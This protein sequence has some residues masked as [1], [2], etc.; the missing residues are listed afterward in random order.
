[1]NSAYYYRGLLWKELRY[2]ARLFGLAF[3]LISWQN[4]FFPVIRG[5]LREGVTFAEWYT[6]LLYMMNPHAFSSSFM[7]QIGIIIS[8]AMGVLILNH[9]RSGSL[10]YLLS[11]PVHRKEIIVSK[12]ISGSLALA[13]IMFINAL[14]VVL[15]LAAGPV[16]LVSKTMVIGWFFSMTVAWIC[17]FTLGLAASTLCRNFAAAGLTALFIFALPGM[18]TQFAC[19]AAT[20]FFDASGKLALTIHNSMGRMD[21][22]S[23]VT[24]KAPQKV[25]SVDATSP[26]S[27]GTMSSGIGTETPNYFV[28]NND[29]VFYLVGLTV[30]TV[31]FLVAAVWFFERNPL[32]RKGDWLMFGHFKHVAIIIIAFL[33]AWSLGLEYAGS[34]LSFAAYFV[35]F[36]VLIYLMFIILSRLFGFFRLREWMGK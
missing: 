11:T 19:Q 24:M 35:L 2:N 18:I 28:I 4:L 7:V 13:G 8:I 9:E 30:L 31:I 32:E 15:V 5:L 3:I 14:V 33:M 34:L 29:I 10:E 27:I 6:T 17:L 21:V 20:H 25:D 26:F 36:F 23:M 22:W 1:M 16:V 12:F